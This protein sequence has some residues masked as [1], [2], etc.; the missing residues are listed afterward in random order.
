MTIV[1]VPTEQE[2]QLLSTLHTMRDLLTSIAS[3]AD[4]DYLHDEFRQLDKELEYLEKSFSVV[5]SQ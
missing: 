4:V 2:R 3:A 5:V 1:R